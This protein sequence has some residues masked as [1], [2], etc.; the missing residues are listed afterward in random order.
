MKGSKFNLMAVISIVVLLFYSYIV[1]MGLTYKFEG[2]LL[3]SGLWTG[4]VVLLVGLSVL[5]MSAS[6][7]TRW[8]GIGLTG[9][10][11]F[12]AIALVTLLV[13]SMPF[14]HFFNIV[15]KQDEIKTAFTETLNY[16]EGI[17]KA[18]KE[19]AKE[20]E[21]KYAYELEQAVAG[22]QSDAARY[23]EMINA[24]GDT[25]EQKMK[26]LKDY[27]HRNLYN[28]IDSVDAG[29]RREWFRSAS[30]MSVW[31]IQ[32][33]QNLNIIDTKVAEWEQAYRK[34]S[35]V[36]TTGVKYEPFKYEAYNSKTKDL[37]DMFTK[38]SY[39]T[40][41]SVL[42]AVFCFLVMIMPYLLTSTSVISKDDGT[43]AI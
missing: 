29:A 6:K 43:I 28:G 4:L 37:R 19:Y 15:D 2:N 8:K 16:A 1:L 11:V 40:W 23:N 7:A 26:N 39:P 35:S 42:A 10:I 12:G 18:Y 21:E 36:E 14:A 41:W 33:P 3:K 34:N 20:R 13:S 27:L 24:Y 22:R 5:I 25:D 30:E 9:Q 38:L 17:D 32:L 31:N